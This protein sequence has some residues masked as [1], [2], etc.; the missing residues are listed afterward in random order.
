MVSARSTI[1]EVSSSNR[2]CENCSS[3][4]TSHQAQWENVGTRLGLVVKDPR[5]KFGQRMSA[6]S[7]SLASIPGQDQ[8]YLQLMVA[9]EKKMDAEMEK[10]AE[11]EKEDQKEKER[12]M[13]QNL[14]QPKSVHLGRVF[15]WAQSYGFWLTISQQVTNIVKYVS[16]LCFV[17]FQSGH[18]NSSFR[19]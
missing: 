2:K 10:E 5:K 3:S 1:H 8:F 17:L 13:K 6:S 4:S 18:L 14:S 15:S 12:I 11:K 7:S 9:W 16:S 19:I